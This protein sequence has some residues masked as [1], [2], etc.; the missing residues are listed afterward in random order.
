MQRTDQKTK[1]AFDEPTPIFD[2]FNSG[3]TGTPVGG[4]LLIIITTL[5]VFSI[6]LSF[7]SLFGKKIIGNYPSIISEIKIICFT[8]ISFGLLGVYDD[9]SKIFFWKKNNFFGLRIRHKLILEVILA[10]IVAYWLY[11]DLKIDII[12]VPFLGVYH[13][14]L[15]YILFAAFVIVAFANAVNV[16]D[17]LDGLASGVLLVSVSSF[18]VVARSIVDVPTSLFVSSWIGGLFAFL[19]FNIY[20]ARLIMGDTG[21]LSFGATFAVIGLI[22]GKAFALPIVGGVFVIEIASS[23]VQ[24]LS[25]KFLKKKIVPV[26]PFHLWLQYRGWGEPKVVMRIW[27]MS[28]IFAILGLMF[29]FMK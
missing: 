21:A 18:W 25:K 9:L 12:Y 13:L 10:L 20:P 29:A 16:T 2:R 7:F 8:F 4:G 1:D 5:V 22:L 11:N 19:Y 24:L 14:W 6:F 26:S 17:G 15:F 28:I 23:L 27:L 3:K